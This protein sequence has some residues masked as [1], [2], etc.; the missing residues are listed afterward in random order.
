MFCKRG[1]VM[2]MFALVF[3]KSV[4]VICK[5]GMVCAGILQIQIGIEQ[6]RAG[7]AKVWAGIPRR[8]WQ[9]SLNSAGVLEIRAGI[10]KVWAGIP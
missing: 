10:V 6:I 1:L 5:F 8:L 2:L 4:W 7:I 3:N 9:Y